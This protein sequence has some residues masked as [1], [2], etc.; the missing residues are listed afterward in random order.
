MH[1]KKLIN[2]HERDYISDQTSIKVGGGKTIHS[3]CQT[4]GSAVVR[5]LFLPVCAWRESVRR[6]VAFF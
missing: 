3:R 5:S 1:L 2:T 4:A 6:I